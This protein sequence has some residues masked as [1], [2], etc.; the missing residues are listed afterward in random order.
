MR[1]VVYA[2]NLKKG[3]IPD[4]VPEVVEVERPFVV[5]DV[6]IEV[7]GVGRRGKTR[8]N[9]PTIL[10]DCASSAVTPIAAQSEIPESRLARENTVFGGEFR[11]LVR[12]KTSEV[13]PL[14][15]PLLVTLK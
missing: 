4:S 5:D 9:S 7:S 3:G 1:G 10:R 2:E 14:L 6:P 12:Y 15:Q 13:Q 11:S 8:R